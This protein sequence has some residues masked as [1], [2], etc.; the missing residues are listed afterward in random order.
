M[1]FYG[2]AG[3]DI[4][5]GGY[6][7]DVL[8]YGG[9]GND[10]LSSSNFFGSSTM[11]GGVGNDRIDGARTAYGDAGNDTIIGGEYSYHGYGFGTLYGGD[12]NDVILGGGPDDAYGGNGNDRLRGGDIWGGSGSD[13]FY[14]RGAVSGGYGQGTTIAA[15]TR[16]KDFQAG[17][18][19]L[20]DGAKVVTGNY[21]SDG[22]AILRDAE[23]SDIELGR[24]GN[25]LVLSG[26]L[27]TDAYNYQVRPT[28]TIEGFFTKG[29]TSITIDG[30]NTSVIGL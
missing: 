12:G 24:S 28:M 4:V 5:S 19:I 9:N 29:L 15:A 23:R 7:S 6:M 22:Y 13:A 17:E 10:S 1:T 25:S 8:A 20:L 21:D 16:V 2:E 14:F 18:R 27:M 3:N 11:Y 26:P 30:V